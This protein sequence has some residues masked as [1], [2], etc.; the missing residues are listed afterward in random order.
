MYMMM[1]K[2]IKSAN[3]TYEGP[4]YTIDR[5]PC[6]Y[7]GTCWNEA[8]RVYRSYHGYNAADF[9]SRVG[10]LSNHKSQLT[11]VWVCKLRVRRALWN[12]MSC[13]EALHK[14]IERQDKILA[15]FLPQEEISKYRVTILLLEGK[16]QEEQKQQC[17]PT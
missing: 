17:I 5:Q 11:Y 1:D 2:R 8:K 16:E 12:G 14:E 9:I 13:M 15:S 4:P 7:C 6:A 10:L 3:Y